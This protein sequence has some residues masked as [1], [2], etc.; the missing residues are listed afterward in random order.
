MWN[1]ADADADADAEAEAKGYMFRVMQT[2]TR[3]SEY[4]YLSLIHI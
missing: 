4:S 3:L 2:E 1:D